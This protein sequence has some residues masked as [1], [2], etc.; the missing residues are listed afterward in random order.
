ME[1]SLQSNKVVGFAFF[2]VDDALITLNSMLSFQDYWYKTHNDHAAE[3]AFRQAVA[4]HRQPNACRV[5][6]NRMYYQ[7]FSGLLEADVMDTGRRWFNHMRGLYPNFYNAPVLAELRAHQAAGREVVLVSGS[8]AGVLNPIARDLGIDC[9]L[10]CSQEVK[11]GYYTGELLTVPM[12]GVGK[13]KAL[14]SY[15]VDATVAE[16]S[17]AYGDDVSD[18]PMLAL[19]GNPVVVGGGRIPPEQ[20]SDLGW[21]V[22]PAA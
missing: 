10:A 1:A 14:A 21:R 11:D 5:T 8:F 2:D 17:Y 4:K 3:A 13:Q 15:L 12:I 19:V 20:L 22:L 6:L 9:V 16:A 7:H 18:I